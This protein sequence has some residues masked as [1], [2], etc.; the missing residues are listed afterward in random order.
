MDEQRNYLNQIVLAQRQQLDVELLKS[1]LIR[2]KQLAVAVATTDIQ[3]AKICCANFHPALVILD[4]AF[5]DN[6]ALEMGEKILSA[7][8]AK[9]CLLLDEY[10]NLTRAKTAK[11][12]S[13][14]YF[15]RSIGADKILELIQCIVTDE[16]AALSKATH[17]TDP[18]KYLRL[19]C[20]IVS[21]LSKREIEVMTLLA[22]GNSVRSCAKR[23]ELSESTVD[24]HKSR[25]MKKLDVHKS[26][27]LVRLA[28]RAGL[29]NL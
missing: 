28:I 2:D 5:P 29:I 8:D 15:T 6:Q 16:Q 9:H 3:F 22:E 26:A 21:R 14:F 11:R 4:A 24:N 13:A 7:G 23:L 25:L 18:G 19:D 1:L 20:P 10:Y 12:I 17:L 27:D